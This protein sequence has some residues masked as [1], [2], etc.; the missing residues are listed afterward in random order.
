MSAPIRLTRRGKAV[1]ALAVF[2]VTFIAWDLTHDKCWDY[3]RGFGYT[4]CSWAQD[5]K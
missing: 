1:A 4:T 5:N 3:D 2:T